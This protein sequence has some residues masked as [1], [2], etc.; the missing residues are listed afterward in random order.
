VRKLQ[1]LFCL[2]TLN[3]QGNRGELRLA[4]LFTG[5]W[6]IAYKNSQKQL[7]IQFIVQICA[8]LKSRGCN[9]NATCFHLA[10]QYIRA[11]YFS[12][13]AHTLVWVN[14][15]LDFRHSQPVKF[16]ACRQLSN[17]RWSQRRLQT[18]P[19]LRPALRPLRAPPH[20]V[21]HRR[22]PPKIELRFRGTGAQG[23]LSHRVR[24]GGGSR[25]HDSRA[26]RPPS[27][28]GHLRDRHDEEDLRWAKNR[29]RR[30]PLDGADRIREGQGCSRFRMWRCA[31]QQ[32][33]RL[34][35]GALHQREGFAQNLET[36]GGTAD[37]GWVLLGAIAGRVCAWGSTT[38]RLTL[39]ASTT[40][41]T[42]TVRRLLSISRSRRP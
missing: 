9:S 32:E 27:G 20:L 16:S 12:S 21:Q 13:F 3:R 23:V 42:R 24:L 34:D 25:G 18:H 11:S 39:I 41:W 29:P 8:H 10:I 31:H 5:N 7:T 26:E 4:S 28:Q 19:R 15:R 30:V 1:Q 35:G 17:P 38:L 36:V 40:A 2:Q 33:V 37:A 6:F 14:Q 22:L